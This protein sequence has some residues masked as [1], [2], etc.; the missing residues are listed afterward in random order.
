LTARARA[1]IGRDRELAR[2]VRRKANRERFQTAIAP[3]YFPPSAD[4]RNQ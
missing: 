4:R 3:V 1:I 2:M